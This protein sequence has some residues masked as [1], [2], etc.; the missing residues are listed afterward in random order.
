MLDMLIAI[1]IP[2][3]G[4]SA[5]ADI[6]YVACP[7]EDYELAACYWDS[8]IRGNGKGL[9]FVRHA[10]GTIEF[11]DPARAFPSR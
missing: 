4:I 2:D 11:V 6:V 5:R 8:R 9:S 10:D 7:T 1:P 3:E